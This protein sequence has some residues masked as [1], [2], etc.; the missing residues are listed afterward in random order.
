MTSN[1]IMEEME[2]LLRRIDVGDA[3]KIIAK[4]GSFGRL[5]RLLDFPKDDRP[6]IFTSKKYLV[7][8]MYSLSYAQGHKDRMMSEFIN[9]DSGIEKIIYLL[10]A[11]L[12]SQGFSLPINWLAAYTNNTQ[13][14]IDKLVKGL[15]SSVIRY[16]SSNPPSISMQSR[17]FAEDFMDQNNTQS[18]EYDEYRYVKYNTLETFLFWI[19]KHV[20]SEHPNFHSSYYRVSSRLLSFSLLEKWFSL[21]EVSNLYGVVRPAWQD[22]ARFWEQYA[23]LKL[24]MSDYD[25]A[26]AYS[27]QATRIYSDAF[28]LNTLGLI[29]MKSSYSMHRPGSEDSLRLFREGIKYLTESRESRRG[30]DYPYT[31]FFTYTIRFA[32]SSQTKEKWL[33]DELNGYFTEWMFS[34]RQNSMFSGGHNKIYLDR[35]R[36]EWLRAISPIEHPQIDSKNIRRG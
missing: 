12:A 9:L 16:E 4:L 3:K 11:S 33:L 34:A 32:N 31:T 21:E 17:V 27:R 6:K 36:L 24:A 13:L 15:D 8:A 29:L 1:G 22:N 7:N 25:K 20:D 26:I 2:I 28:T 30:D 10:A 23:L 5:D 18:Q 35:M 19:A 14:D